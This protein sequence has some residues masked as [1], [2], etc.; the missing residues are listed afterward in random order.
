[1]RSW[2]ALFTGAVGG[3]TGTTFSTATEL[4]IDITARW[5]LKVGERCVKINE[6]WYVLACS[7][8]IDYIDIEYID[9][10]YSD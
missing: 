10:E 7:K 6:N 4:D 3:E 9:I 1:M 8:L 2:K 5:K